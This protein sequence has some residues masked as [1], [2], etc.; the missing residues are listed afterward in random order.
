MRRGGS[1]QDAADMLGI[2]R[3]TVNNKIR[4]IKEHFGIGFDYPGITSLS[5]AIALDD[6]KG[7][8]I[9]R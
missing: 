8:R 2:H 9:E 4:F 1:V 5:V 6:M 3:N 7:V